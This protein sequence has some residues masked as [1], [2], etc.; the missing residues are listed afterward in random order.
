M[1]WAREEP[2]TTIL[3]QYERARAVKAAALVATDAQGHG[4]TRL[5][6]HLR[7]AP[8]DGGA[9]FGSERVEE[10]PDAALVDPQS[11]QWIGIPH[12]RTVRPWACPATTP[13][14]LRPS[15]RSGSRGAK[16]SACLTRESPDCRA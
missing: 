8:V 9:L 1:P 3:P 12:A 5:P 13:A 15:R 10:R 7:K 6:H 16:K 14:M 4:D 2:R 11:G